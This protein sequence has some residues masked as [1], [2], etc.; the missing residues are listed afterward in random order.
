MQ[1]GV[2][3]ITNWW[4]LAACGRNPLVRVVDRLELVVI[5]LAIPAG[6]FAAAGA[7]ALGTAVHE[8]CS[9]T[10]AAQSQMRQSAT[11]TAATATAAGASIETRMNA[12]CGYASAC[13]NAIPSH[14]ALIRR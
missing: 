6:P 8:A 12:R 14:N 2:V 10:H 9:S 3:P 4:L 13:H 1:N 11:A 5:A 7:G